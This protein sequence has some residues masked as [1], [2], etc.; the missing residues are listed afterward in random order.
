MYEIKDDEFVIKNE[1]LVIIGN[2]IRTGWF[3]FKQLFPCLYYTTYQEDD[4]TVYFGMY[5]QWFGYMF[6]IQTIP[7]GSSYVDEDEF[8]EMNIDEEDDYGEENS[9]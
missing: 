7:I 5:R 8:E 2:I 9:K 4:G 6:A 3:Y 1:S